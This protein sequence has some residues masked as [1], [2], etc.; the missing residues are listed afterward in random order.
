MDDCR[1]MRDRDLSARLPSG[2]YESYRTC[3]EALI[4]SVNMEHMTTNVQCVHASL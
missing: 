1:T 3:R 4:R 2:C